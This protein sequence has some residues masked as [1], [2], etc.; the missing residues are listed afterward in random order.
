MEREQIGDNIGRD[1]VGRDH[2]QGNQINTFEAATLQEL[3][4]L[5]ADLQIVRQ[6]INLLKD[7]YGQTEIIARDTIQ[8]LTRATTM[9]AAEN[10]ELYKKTATLFK[11]VD[12]LLA[13]LSQFKTYL[14]WQGI[15]IA[16]NT[17]ATV[18][19]TV[20]MFIVLW[21]TI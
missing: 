11:R 19:V 21:K 6:D 8:A 14:Y 10:D 17:T 12:A 7:Q 15:G 2:I 18:V 9:L 4:A 20:T 16:I 13:E 1:K 5:N 3:R